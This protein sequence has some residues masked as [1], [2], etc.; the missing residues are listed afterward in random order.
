MKIYTKTGDS[1]DTSLFGGRRVPKS[2]SRIEAYGT[3]DELNAHLGSISALKPDIKV[4]EILD[5]IQNHLFALGADLATP[6]EISSPKIQRI[7][8]DDI[9]KIEAI[10]D[11][12]DAQLE[13]LD[14]FIFPGGSPASA[15]LHIARTICRRAER[16]VDA[17]GRK[18][19]IGKFLLIYLNRLADLL[20]VLARYV[21]NISGTKEKKWN[22]S[23]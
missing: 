6:I 17:L 4:D 16:L 23:K 2:S 8:S 18:E 14:T 15:Q 13:P 11:Q 3:V 20:F 9:Q 19:D 5:Q 10:I 7:K 1:G 21:N 22:V 12:L